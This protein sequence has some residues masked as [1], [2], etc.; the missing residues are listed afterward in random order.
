[1]KTKA[2]GDGPVIFAE[3]YRLLLDLYP[4]V[5]RFP[6]AQQPV[7]GR[8]MEDAALAL[9]SG[10]LEANAEAAKG[11]RLRAMSVELEKLRVLAR[12]AK[13]LSF[14]SFGQ[15]EA[16]VARVDGIGRMLGGWI[17]W[18]ERGAGGGGQG[19]TVRMPPD[20]VVRR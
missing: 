4:A 19:P 8:R 11:P 10:I 13:D 20:G 12:L 6:R 3:A 2:G 17:K 15:Y 16:L 18:A 7:L 9:L 5:R 1:M 14:L